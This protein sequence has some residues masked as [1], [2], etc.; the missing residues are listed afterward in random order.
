MARNHSRDRII[1]DFLVDIVRLIIEDRT[2]IVNL[3]PLDGL[4]V[5]EVISYYIDSIAVPKDPINH[6][7]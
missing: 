1:K 3:A 5:K 2:E 6:I 4:W 7:R